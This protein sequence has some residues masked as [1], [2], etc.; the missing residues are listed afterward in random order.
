MENG[1]SEAPTPAAVPPEAPMDLNLLADEARQ[2]LNEMLPLLAFDVQMTSAI[3]GTNV[4]IQM[5]CGDAARLIGR[6]GATINEIQFLVN[7]I[8]QRRH[9]NVPRFY[10]DVEGGKEAAAIAD[11]APAP[12]SAP[13]AT[14][15]PS[16]SQAPAPV[17]IRTPAPAPRIEPVAPAPSQPPPPP[18]SV[19]PFMDR[20][21]A[22]A[23]KVRRWGDPVDL[24]PMSAEE[25]DSAQSQL[26][27]DREV[28][29]I[30]VE[31]KSGPQ[32]RLQVRQ[33]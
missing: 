3:E 12:M 5:K 9:K 15:T 33:K 27:R 8:L 30:L 6:R 19:N 32:I 20:V 28:E 23:D 10:L 21:K 31:T 26:A 16:A 2:I 18:V 13:A 29:A 22:A 17:P 25:R 24:G 4:R 11:A 14:N 7:R 1:S